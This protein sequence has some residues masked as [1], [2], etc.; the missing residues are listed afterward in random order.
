[1]RTL[2]KKIKKRMKLHVDYVTKNITYMQMLLKNVRKKT[3]PV[4]AHAG[5]A[6]TH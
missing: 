5:I 3:V 6:I 1:M 2:R 4:F